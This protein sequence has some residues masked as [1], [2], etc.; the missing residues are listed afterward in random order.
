MNRDVISKWCRIGAHHRCDSR[1]PPPEPSIP[2][3]GQLACACQCHAVVKRQP[4][5]GGR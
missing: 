2:D 1:V 3:D 5:Y 4:A